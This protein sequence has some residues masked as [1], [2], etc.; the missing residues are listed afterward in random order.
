M[1]ASLA[2]NG[3]PQS[4]EAQMLPQARVPTGK[5]GGGGV[6]SLGR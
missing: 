5:D 4:P 1:A 2:S 3:Q 6:H